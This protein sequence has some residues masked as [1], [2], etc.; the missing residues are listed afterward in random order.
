MKENT[1]NSDRIK[2]ALYGMFIG[3]ALAMPVHWYYDREALKRDYGRVTNYL[4]PKNPHPDSILWRSSY[5][6]RNRSADILHDQAQYWGRRGIHYHQFLKAG[7]NTL[8]IKLAREWLI[9]AE[10]DKIYSSASWLTHLVGFMTTPGTHEDTYI[11]EYLRHFFTAYGKGASLSDCGRKDENHIGGLALFLPVLI[12]FSKDR[13]HARQTA[14][15]HLALTHGGSVMAR[16][17]RLIADIL[18]DVLYGTSLTDAILSQ[19][20]YNQHLESLLD[21]PDMVVVG[22]HFSPACYLQESIP[23]TLYLALKYA[24]DPY[25]ALIANTMCGGDNAGRGAVLGALLGAFHG[26]AAWPEQWVEGL[27]D[28]PPIP[29]L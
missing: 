8:N 23:A 3:D 9:M 25:E 28:P 10:R 1:M 26:M 14:L 16:G 19:D 6:P 4:A 18:L 22:S 7:E 13:D 24:D 11:E 17:G 20:I 12:V 29:V 2:G 21:F 5:T 27:V 15:Q